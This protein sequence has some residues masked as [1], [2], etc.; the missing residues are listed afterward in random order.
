MNIVIVSRVYLWKPYLNNIG[1]DLVSSRIAIVDW[2][3]YSGLKAALGQLGE[4]ATWIGYTTAQQN[5]L[6]T[7]TRSQSCPYA[8]VIVSDQVLELGTFL[9]DQDPATPLGLQPF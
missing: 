4:G 8:E 3:L 7:T 1:G 6:Q 9:G 5:W 2:A